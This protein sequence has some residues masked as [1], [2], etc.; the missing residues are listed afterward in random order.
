MKLARTTHTVLVPVVGTDISDD[1]MAIASA[2]LERPN[3]RLVILHVEAPGE[4]R[5]VSGESTSCVTREPRW[6]RLALAAGTARTFVEAV[7]ADSMSQVL[8]EAERYR[9]D[10]VILDGTAFERPRVMRRRTPHVCQTH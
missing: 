1:T 4:S 8:D 9:C 3:S 5:T 2:L 10:A 6:H 7:E